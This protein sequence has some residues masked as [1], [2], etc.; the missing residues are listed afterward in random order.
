MT[1]FPLAMSMLRLKGSTCTM[2]HALLV[3]IETSY[4]RRVSLLCQLPA[5]ALLPSTVPHGTVRGRHRLPVPVWGE[6]LL[7]RHPHRPG[8]LRGGAA[9]PTLQHPGRAAQQGARGQRLR[10]EAQH[11]AA[12][13][14]LREALREHGPQGGAAVLLLPAGD[15][16]RPGGQPLHVL[17]GRA[18]AREQGV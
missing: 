16:G 14:A 5:C 15:E 3:L 9:E 8:P 2:N 7:P 12:A 17:R 10:P 6:S 1:A 4:C 13:D 18:R 11:R